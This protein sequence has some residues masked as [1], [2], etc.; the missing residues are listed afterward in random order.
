MRS[1]VVRPSATL[2]GGVERKEARSEADEERFAERNRK[3]NGYL[4]ERE[5]GK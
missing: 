5:P 4:G 1:R 2:E 3:L